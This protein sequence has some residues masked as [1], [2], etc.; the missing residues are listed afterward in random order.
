[1]NIINFLNGISTIIIYGIGGLQ[2]IYGNLTIGALITFNQYSQKLFS[3]IIRIVENTITFKKA[4]I[5][6]YKIMNIL[7]ERTEYEVRNGKKKFII[8]N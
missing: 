6:I 5:S 7:N 3:P 2:I 4:K 8:S 1:M